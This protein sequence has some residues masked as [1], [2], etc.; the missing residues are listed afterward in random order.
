MGTPI[1]AGNPPNRT[2]GIAPKTANAP[3]PPALATGQI[4]RPAQ[5]HES[6]TDFSPELHPPWHYSAALSCHNAGV[7]IDPSPAQSAGTVRPGDPLVVA[8]SVSKSYRAHVALHDATFTIER[9]VTGLL[10]ANG[11]G[12]TT[13]LG[14]IIGLH[15]V[16]GGTLRVLGHDPWSAGSAVRERLGYAPEHHT[17]P[18]DLK[19]ADFV[20]HVAE[21]HG[22]PKEEAQTRA[23]DALW[24]VG[25][26][27]ERFRPMGTMSTGQR[28]RVKL[29]QAIA[30]DPELVL[31]DEPTDGLD[32]IQRDAMLDLIKGIA[33]DFGINVILSSH[34]LD[35]V[36]RICDAAVII[37]DGRTLASGSLTSLMGSTSGVHVEFDGAPASL[38]AAF[39]ALR[40]GGFVVSGEGRRAIVEAA[41]RDA[42]VDNGCGIARLTRKGR[43]LEDI[44][45]E[46]TFT[47]TGGVPQ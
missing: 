44:F 17:L 22:L 38:D 10:G 9:G 1:L 43:S 39:A 5:L 45:L 30:H 15:G 16:S 6:C 20:R 4:R 25:L 3:S 33:R 8:Q 47:P 37:G 14:M 19:A 12:K 26:G 40:A 2:V 31:L 11:A 29:A 41:V 18:P 42:A 28:Q 23:S 36:E 7:S 46:E 34:L 32:P 24:L 13:L 35:E 21:L 27:E